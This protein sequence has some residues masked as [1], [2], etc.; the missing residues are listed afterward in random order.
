MPI[1]NKCRGCKQVIPSPKFVCNKDCAKIYRD[2]Q[3]QINYQ[4]NKKT[5]DGTTKTNS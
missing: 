2:T 1:S 5:T 3:Q 4:L